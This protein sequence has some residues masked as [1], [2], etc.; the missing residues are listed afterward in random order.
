MTSL[1]CNE[2]AAV[3][4]EMSLVVFNDVISLTHC[5]LVTP[6]GNINLDQHWIGYWSVAWWHQA[7][8]LNQFW[9]LIC[10]ILWH[11]PEIFFTANAVPSLLYNEFQNYL[12]PHFSGTNEL[13]KKLKIITIQSKFECKKSN[14]V[15]S[16][17]PADGLALSDTRPSAGKV[18]AQ[19]PVL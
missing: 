19:N 15:V 9:H 2:N 18:M 5:G 12:E 7:N 4:H 6:Y 8:Y 1:G 17:V 10:E 13:M 16:I 14:F 11:S 3:S